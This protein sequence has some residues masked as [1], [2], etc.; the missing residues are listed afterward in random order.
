MNHKD[1]H[2]AFVG[3]MGLLIIGSI[4]LH[5]P[6]W[7]VGFAILLFIYGLMFLIIEGVKREKR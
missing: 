4:R 7:T 5:K 6:D 1:I 3:C 2:G